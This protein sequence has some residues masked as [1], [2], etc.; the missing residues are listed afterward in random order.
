[1]GVTT[2]FTV[3]SKSL[4]L[5]DAYVGLNYQM[6]KGVFALFYFPGEAFLIA[7]I[8]SAL[9]DRLKTITLDVPAAAKRVPAI[10]LLYKFIVGI[11]FIFAG[12][13]IV[14]HFTYAQHVIFAVRGSYQTDPLSQYPAGWSGIAASY[15]ALTL[16]IGF[17][18]LG[19][20][21]YLSSCRKKQASLN[22]NEVH[23]VSLCRVDKS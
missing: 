17:N 16:V 21:I 19:F 11:A 12:I 4:F 10:R 20:S 9:A 14:V 6:S 5:A 2:I 7:A 22:Y 13:L 8:F 23:L 15:H 1:M 3:C 18:F